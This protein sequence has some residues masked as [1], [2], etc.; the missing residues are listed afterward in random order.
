MT[1]IFL[2]V[3]N[4]SISASWIVL[5]VLI[6]RFL[7]KK[8]PKWINCILWCIVG[9]RL[10]FPFSIE[11]IMSLMPSKETI[12]PEIMMD[13]TPEIN[14]GVPIINN[15]INPVI[16]QSFA[17]EPMASANPLQILLPIIANVWLI[18]IIG[19]LGCAMNY[20]IYAKMLEK[21]KA[22]YAFEIVELAREISEEK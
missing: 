22:K 6:A 17:P 13:A 16:N 3:V 20:P 21:G 5:A 19:M 7:L 12:N 10:I 4:M 18:G 8:A 9:I 14:T 15:V 2:K 1:D 11:S